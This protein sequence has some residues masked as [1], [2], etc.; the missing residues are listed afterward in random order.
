MWCK[1]ARWNS[2]YFQACSLAAFTEL[3]D[4]NFGHAVQADK[5]SAEP[6][7]FYRRVPCNMLNMFG[8]A[9]PNATF[10]QPDWTVAFFA[11]NRVRC[12][13]FCGGPFYPLID[14][15]TGEFINK[16]YLGFTGVG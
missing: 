7:V 3:R 5:S 13:Y 16:R 15:T 4:F 11:A 1:P 14:F 10:V 12:D 2:V 8:G 9:M 6:A